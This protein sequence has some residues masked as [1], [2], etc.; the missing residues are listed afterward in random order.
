L[1]NSHSQRR[2]PI[3]SPVKQNNKIFKLV[4]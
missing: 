2:K 1:F 4:K 3:G